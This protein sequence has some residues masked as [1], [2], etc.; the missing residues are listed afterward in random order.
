MGILLSIAVGGCSRQ[1]PAG[2]HN[3]FHPYGIEHVALHFEYFGAI[4]G[5]EDIYID[6]FGTREVHV[7]NSAL[8]TPQGF[9]PTITYTMRDRGKIVVV[10]SIRRLEAKMIDRT[11]DS[12]YHLVPTDV[13]APQA[14]LR[15]IYGPQAYTLAGDTTVLG[16]PAHI[17]RHSGIPGFLLVWRGIIVGDRATIQGQVKELRLMSF[18]TTTP[19]NSSIFTPPSGFPI[20]DFTNP[21]SGQPPPPMNP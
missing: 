15:D 12:I 16:L 5:S 3:N 20:H 9:E 19:I 18:D 14:V 6:S 13:P 11:M 1:L 10:D 17:W 8:I 7:V 4:R 21:E 2:E